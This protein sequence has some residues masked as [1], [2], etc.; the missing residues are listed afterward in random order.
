MEGKVQSYDS[1]ERMLIMHDG[2]KVWLSEG[3]AVEGLKEGSVVKV[4]FEE[5]DGKAI[6]TKI[7]IAN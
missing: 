1:G 5:R 4:V 2:T 6:V 3:L 7:E